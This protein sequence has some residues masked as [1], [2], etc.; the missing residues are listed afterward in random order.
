MARDKNKANFELLK[1][2]VLVCGQE[3]PRRFQRAMEASAGWTSEIRSQFPI[4]II[5]AFPKPVNIWKFVINC[6]EDKQP[7]RVEVRF[8]APSPHSSKPKSPNPDNENPSNGPTYTDA[9]NAKYQKHSLITFEAKP[10]K[11]RVTEEKTL[12][13][14]VISQFV[15]IIL[16][17]PHDGKTIQIKQ[18]QIFGYS[19]IHSSDEDSERRKREQKEIDEEEKKLKPAEKDKNEESISR[20]TALLS[21][22]DLE[23]YKGQKMAY[24]SEGDGLKNSEENLGS[25]PLTSVRTI[26][27]VLK[28]KMAKAKAEDKII[29]ATACKRG[30]ERLDEY[31]E[32]IFELKKKMSTAL[33]HNDNEYA[34]R[35]RLAMIDC[36]DTVFRAIHLDLLLNSEELRSMGIQSKWSESGE[37]KS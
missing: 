7:K 14:D 34:E 22:G 33:Q 20:L 28:Q 21:E 27:N 25:E 2:K 13:M 31:D 4:D 5:L 6:A 37:K 18:L 11:E 29:E 15:W 35:Y 12:F 26:K 19:N 16:D 32:R 3:S 10:K 1:W 17:G 23:D 30:I 36:R 8:G 24:S 9:K